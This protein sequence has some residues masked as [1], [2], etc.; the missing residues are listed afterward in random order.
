MTIYDGEERRRETHISEDQ[1]EKIAERAADK[2]VAKVTDEVY[3]LVGKSVLEKL[4]Y[5]V[6]AIAVGAYFW[7]QSKGVVK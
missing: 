6:G 2:A 3:K 4:F 7:M 1:I 5:I